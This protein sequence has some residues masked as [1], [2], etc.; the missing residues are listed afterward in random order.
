VI[1]VEK[2]A[3]KAAHK[4]KKECTYS[5]PQIASIG[6]TEEQAMQGGYDTKIGKLH[7]NLNGKSIAFS[8]TEGLVKTIIDRKTGELLGAHV[9]GAEVTELISNF[10]LAKQLEVTVN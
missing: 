5:H 3:G 9:I 10:A 8:E 7:S 4:L 6:L 1:C 2:I